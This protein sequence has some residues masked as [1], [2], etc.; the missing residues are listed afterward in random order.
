M[1]HILVYLQRTLY[2]LHPGSAVALCLA[3][4]I[5][6]ERGATVTAL[7]AGDAGPMDQ[8]IVRAAS[9]YGADVV[10]FTG[11]NGLEHMQ[12]RLRPVHILTPWTTEGEAAVQGLPGG[13]ATPR[14]LDD[15][16]PRWSEPDAITGVVAG[17][18]PWHDLGGELEPE[19]EGDVGEVPMPAWVKDAPG[20]GEAVGFR[21]AAD[22]PIQFH[23]PGGLDDATE[24]LLSSIGAK[25]LPADALGSALSG[26]VVWLDGTSALPESLAQR[27][28]DSRLILLPGPDAD[29]LPSWSHAD[30]VLP[31]DTAETLRQLQSELWRSALV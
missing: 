8:G 30:W 13:P 9:T 3:R 12:T 16:Q 21:A 29:I 28:P 19:Y 27:G 7:C 2:G 17:T 22:G 1:A 4:D 20:E 18:L 14:W 11:P 31:G 23:A 24:A 15:P 10:L 5:G 26:T 25:P 6:S